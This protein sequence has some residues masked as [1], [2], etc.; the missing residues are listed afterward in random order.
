MEIAQVLVSSTDRQFTVDRDSV[1]QAQRAIKAYIE[2]QIGGGG[3]SIERE[4]CYSRKYFQ[5]PNIN[6]NGCWASDKYK[7]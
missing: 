1:V 6:Y 3:A 5:A 2:A 4:Q 7:C